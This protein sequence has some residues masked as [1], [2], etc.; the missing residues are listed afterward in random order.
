MNVVPL[1]FLRAD[2]QQHEIRADG[3]IRRL[4]GDHHRVE[5]AFEALKPSVNHGDDIAADGVHLRVKFAA[6]HTIAEIDQTR[7]CIR[8]HNLRLL[9]ERFQ[10]DYAGCFVNRLHRDRGL[11]EILRGAVLG[12]IERFLAGRKHP[13]G[14]QRHKLAIALDSVGH[15]LDA[16]GIP[17]LERPKLPRKSPAHRAIHIHDAIRNL[18]NTPCGVRTHLTDTAPQKPRSFVA[19]L[20]I[21]HRRHKRAQPFARIFNRLSCFNRSEPSFLLRPVV[22]LLPVQR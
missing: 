14:K 13:L 11:I 6:H 19:A 1:L 4:I 17:N 5:F 7:T 15:S 9:F 3:K 12:L 8:L 2:E 10:N 16:D 22:H 18:R 20:A 21:E